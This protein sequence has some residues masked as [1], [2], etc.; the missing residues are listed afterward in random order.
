M[1]AEADTADGPNMAFVYYDELHRAKS[2]E[3]YD[4]IKYAGTAIE[5]KTGE[6]P[7]LICT[8]TAGHNRESICY[9]VYS[10]AKRVQTGEVADDAFYV[11]I[12]EADPADDWTDEKTWHEANPSLGTPIMPLADFRRDFEEARNNPAAENRFRRL[13]LNQ[14]TE[15]ATRWI[16]LELWDRNGGTIDPAAMR[17]VNV[18]A[19]WT[20]PAPRIPPPLSSSSGTTE[21]DTTFSPR[22]SCPRRILR[23]GA[24]AMA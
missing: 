13:R 14:W 18:G 6:I 23:I 7:L 22:F 24:D 11:Y 17:A 2:R 15:Q 19:V 4:T 1:S 21:A 8:T 5:K 9:E 3:L 12:A 16:P 20:S 10:Y